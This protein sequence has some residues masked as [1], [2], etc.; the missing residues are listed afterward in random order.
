MSEL[1][2]LENV[3]K[4]Y[5][6][7]EEDVHVLRGVNLSI[8]QGEFVAIMGVSGSGKSTLLHIA[9]ALDTAD[10]GNVFYR[11][12]A[13]STVGRP[14]RH[15][16]RNREFGFVFQLYHLLPELSVVDN[17]LLPA[18]VEPIPQWLVR[19]ILMPSVALV[20]MGMV[21][22]FGYRPGHFP[23]DSLVLLALGLPVLLITS[24]TVVVVDFCKLIMLRGRKRKDALQLLEAFGLS[25][26]LKHRPAELSGG[27]RQR[28]AIA[29]ALINQ[30][31]LLLADE[32]TGNLDAVTGRAILDVLVNLHKTRGQTILMVTHDPSVAALAD[33]TIRLSEG[34]IQK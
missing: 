34:R 31:A 16:L 23:L 26:R 18:M 6:M 12:K 1:L 2:R 11:G 17:V 9:G 19:W 3:H 22:L 28:V 30:P 24:L 33:R 32:P 29:R 5:H 21:A 20:F 13:V 14:A 15:Q 8:E 25:H 10:T 27:E 4:N 7:G